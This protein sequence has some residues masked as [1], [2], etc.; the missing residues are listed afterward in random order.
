MDYRDIQKSIHRSL[1]ELAKPVITKQIRAI[2][3]AHKSEILQLTLDDT[4][5]LVESFLEEGIRKST[6][7][8]YQIL[9]YKHKDFTRE[10][11]QKLEHFVL[12]YVSDWWDCDDYMTHAFM[13]FY[14]RFPDILPSIE[15]WTTNEHFAIRR[16]APVLL[17][18]PAR[19]GLANMEDVFHLCDLVFEDPHY[20]VLK[21][22]GWLL[23]EASRH[24]PKEVISYLEK[25]INTMPRTAFRYALE[26][27]PNIERK[28]LMSLTR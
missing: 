26:K 15:A 25:H 8:A 22:Y 14:L 9:D 23:K 6:I 5:T 18:I 7:V 17:V 21:G 28:R 20:L 3:Q 4:F 11:Y 27:L 24:Y 2:V 19:K 13:R 1:K 12:T 10:S 16:C